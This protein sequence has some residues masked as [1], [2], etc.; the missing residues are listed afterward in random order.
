MTG[1]GVFLCYYG[2]DANFL[3]VYIMRF[4]GEI[5]HRSKRVG[6]NCFMIFGKGCFIQYRQCWKFVQMVIWWCSFFSWFPG[7]FPWKTLCT[8]NALICGTV[9]HIDFSLSHC[10]NFGIPKPPILNMNLIFLWSKQCSF[11][12]ILLV[13]I[14]IVFFIEIHYIP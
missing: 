10:T 13:A 8:F 14:I 1:R 11:V 2:H 9:W 6:K 5:S 3:L 7:I 4:R 12:F